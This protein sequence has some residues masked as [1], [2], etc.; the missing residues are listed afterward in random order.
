MA[1][2]L[3]WE[4]A[5]PRAAVLDADGW[6]SCST[7][8]S[9]NEGLEAWRA[10]PGG[11]FEMKERAAGGWPT[12]RGVEES[13]VATGSDV[14]PGKP[15]SVK[16]PTVLE[17]LDAMRQRRRERRRSSKGGGGGKNASSAESPA[18]SRAAAVKVA[19]ELA[20]A[21]EL[22]PGTADLIHQAAAAGAAA[23]LAAARQQQQPPPG[24]SPSMA[25]AADAEEEEKREEEEE[26][27]E[28]EK[29]NV[30]ELARDL[31]SNMTLEECMARP[32]GKKERAGRG[33]KSRKDKGA[34]K[35]EK[36][37]SKA[38]KEILV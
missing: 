34:N 11:G 13:P 36:R 17:Q 18:E 1:E 25:A 19:K 32:V 29:E 33:K 24:P 2:F 15:S 20:A 35:K 4:F 30:S 14:P 5:T 27:E 12:D 28:E 8:R 3:P 37:A 22:T 9:S 6:E 26:E 23:A 10:T 38:P 16:K 7:G 31:N 21:H